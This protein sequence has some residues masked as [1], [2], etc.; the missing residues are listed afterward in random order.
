MEILKHVA[1]PFR[2]ARTLGHECSA[3]PRKEELC[4]RRE[5]CRIGGGGGIGGLMGAL[6]ASVQQ[7]E[8]VAFLG[9]IMNEEL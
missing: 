3:E 1:W 5:T 6:N 7:E 9:N 8:D 4:A 2:F